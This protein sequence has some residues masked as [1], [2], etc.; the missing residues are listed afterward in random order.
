[1]LQN[2]TDLYFQIKEPSGA[3]YKTKGSRFIATARKV[4]T[5][6]EAQAALDEVAKQYHDATH[7]CYAWKV[8][9]G[10]SMKYR[11][12]DGGEPNNTAGLPIYKTIEARKLTNIIIIVSRYFGG[13]K[14]GT[15][16]LFR[17]YS[18][19]AMDALKDCEIGKVYQM[20]TVMFK[21]SFEFVSVI[22]NIIST[23][24]A[25]LKFKIEVRSSKHK[26]FE[27]KLKDGTNG[28]IEF[29]R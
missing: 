3:E 18:K 29:I 15:G 24:K 6:D 22:H 26:D 9:H 8:G 14:L 5:P 10:K 11:Y 21:T 12:A 28:Q 4:E 20:E 7:H 23:F 25:T 13:V 27:Q 2:S 19:V 16:G 17:A 1:M